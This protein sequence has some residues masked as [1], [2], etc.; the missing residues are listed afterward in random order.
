MH[1]R[2]LPVPP[3]YAR[4]AA[5][6]QDLVA[7][8]AYATLIASGDGAAGGSRRTRTVRHLTPGPA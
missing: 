5:E 8:G 1:W 2:G 3:L 4:M 7:T 6:F